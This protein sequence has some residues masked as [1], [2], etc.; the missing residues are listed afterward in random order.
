[1]GTNNEMVLGL[2]LGTNSVGWALIEYAAGKPTRLIRSGARVF[3][4][5][6]DG[7]AQDIEQGK[8]ESRNAKR[9]E[10]RQQ[11]KQADRRRRRM[12][13]T[14]AALQ[15]MGLLPSGDI[16]DHMARH[17]FFKTLDAQ[18]YDSYKSIGID[19]NLLDQLPYFLRARA[20]DHPLKAH[21]L[22]RAIYHLGHRRGFETNRK[23]TAKDDEEEGQV[24]E[25]ISQLQTM[26]NEARARTLGEYFAGLNPHES[27]IRSRW[28]SRAMYKAE[29]D[30]IWNAQMAHHPDL[31]SEAAKQE[32]YRCIFRQRP[33][34]SQKNLIGQCELEL[35]RKRAPI[36]ILD[37]Q[38]IRMLQRI[39][40][41]CI[42]EDGETI[43]LTAEQREAIISKL[44]FQGD[45][46]FSAIRTLLKL[47]KTTKF[48]LEAGGEEK[49]PGNRTAAKLHAIL[50]ERWLQMPP[51]EQNEL[52]EEILS[53][54]KQETLKSRG[55]KRWKLDSDTAEDLAQIRLE[56][57]YSRFS[58]QALAKLVPRL[59]QGEFLQTAIKNEYGSQRFEDRPLTAL[60]MLEDSGIV[61]RNP[62]V[63]RTLTELRKVVNAII[64]EH[65]KPDLI[66]IELA[67]DMKKPRKKR[68]EAWK[69]NRQRQKQ[70]EAAA[71]QIHKKTGNPHPSREDIER[72][73]LAE[74]CGWECP[75]TGKS[76]GINNLI[77]EQSQFDVEHILPFARCLDDSFMNKTLC[78]HE[79]NRNRKRNK[80]PWE[81]YGESPEWDAIITRVGRFQ[82]DAREAKLR[83][84]KMKS[85]ESLD[86]FTNRQLSDTRYVS[87]I[88]SRFLGLLYGGIVDAAGKKRVQPGRGEVT[89]I[90]R[91]AWNL[92][93]ILSDGPRKSRDDHRH[94][95]IDAIAIALTDTR[96]LKQLSDAA[97]KGGDEQMRRWWKKME[98]PWNTFLQDVQTA[99]ASMIVSHRV[100]RRVS[101]P[102]HEE[103]LYSKIYVDEEG[104]PCVHVRKPIDG[105]SANEVEAIVDR[106]V[107]DAVKQKLLEL[108]TDDTKK[109]FAD[110][111][112]LPKLSRKAGGSV[113]IK[114]VRIRKRASTF[115]IGQT[116]RNRHVV[117]ASNHHMEIIEVLDKKGEPKWEDIIVD[118]YTALQRLR[119][120]QPI[121]QRDHGEGRRFVMSLAI[122]DVLQMNME[123]GSTTLALV[124]G[125]S[126]DRV[127]LAGLVDARLK[128]EIISSGGWEMPR[129]NALRRRS[130]RK[131]SVSPL[132]ALRHSND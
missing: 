85:L 114:R 54:V 56:P 118:Q 129:L 57:G 18:L 98:I 96:T 95:A 124:R 131:L 78:Y 73:L 123:D 52:V 108:G 77:G 2:D 88:A 130:S 100:S 30:A 62:M 68:E 10:A 103:T 42:L 84:F 93:R 75:Y 5:G 126:K 65:G 16:R 71:A 43:P 70:R 15:R 102:L 63:Q 29:F 94:H 48:N 53:T 80:T 41:L 37:S 83:R 33:L 49:L 87:T 31:L 125:I 28:T 116:G 127:S 9:R 105:I 21:A 66:R 22:G 32:I 111:D 61:L 58:R 36:A 64:R 25:G 50:G 76:I 86:S 99:I 82:G 8:D 39:N 24:K 14:A 60:P 121:V 20:L 23:S 97:K 92:N 74:E 27:R 67:R 59:E 91:N 107:Y 90:L 132:G 35:G 128:K 69:K 40:D 45:A 109:A 19:S 120:K 115:Q 4:P 1:M 110:K 104:K 7:T 113:P 13:K 79:E 81:A 46:K 34:K 51:R 3:D 6:V 112:N 44:S 101:G 72:I 55:I 117:P 38:K 122:G 12:A 26:M 106:A 11:R 47:K 119:N 89:A 17:Q